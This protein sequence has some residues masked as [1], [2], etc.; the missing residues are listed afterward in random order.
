MG[1]GA[2]C[3]AR[4]ALGTAARAPGSHVR[5]AVTRRARPEAYGPRRRRGSKRR[6]ESEGGAATGGRRS[7]ACRPPVVS[8]L[9]LLPA[10]RCAAEPHAANGRRNQVG[11]AFC[12]PK[13]GG[14]VKEG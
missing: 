11:Q 6:R 9:P 13:G 4:S 3:R 2:A 8:P 5:R 7:A 1:R 12:Q 10:D 14:G